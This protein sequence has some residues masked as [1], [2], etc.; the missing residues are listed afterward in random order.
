MLVDGKLPEKRAPAH[1]N[2]GWDLK[3]E[4]LSEGAHIVK[5]KTEERF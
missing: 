5:S 3:N 1:E 4:I 2:I